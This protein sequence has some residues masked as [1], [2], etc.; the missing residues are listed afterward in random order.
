MM[1]ACWLPFWVVISFDA[2]F[3]TRHPPRGT[4]LLGCQ[5]QVGIGLLGDRIW[6]NWQ[7]KLAD[8]LNKNWL[9]VV[10]LSDC[11]LKH[12]HR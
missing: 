5:I 2:G 11:Q 9:T 10:F 7:S 6:A 8:F 3:A 12:R 1:L 4:G